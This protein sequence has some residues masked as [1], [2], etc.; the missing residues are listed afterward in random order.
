MS[1]HKH[2]WA[3]MYDGDSERETV[4]IFAVCIADAKAG[5]HIITAEQ[6]LTGN[7]PDACTAT[8]SRKEIEERLNKLESLEE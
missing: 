6:L 1:K 3:V 8:L 2:E 7:L 5:K 4:V